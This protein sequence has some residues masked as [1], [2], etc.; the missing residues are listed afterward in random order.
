MK[1]PLLSL[2]IATVL[3]ACSPTAGPRF[4]AQQLKANEQLAAQNIMCAFEPHPEGKQSPCAHL[5]ENR[6]LFGRIF[7]PETLGGLPE[8]DK[9]RGR[10]VTTKFIVE[11]AAS[12]KQC[13]KVPLESSITIIR[14]VQFAGQTYLLKGTPPLLEENSSCFLTPETEGS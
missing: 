5:I 6:I 11:A 2:S 9:I 12:I 13:R 10:R 7:S 8:G 3:V 1:K 14:D 4:E